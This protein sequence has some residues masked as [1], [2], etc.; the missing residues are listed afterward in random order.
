MNISLVMG[1][2]ADATSLTGSSSVTGE[3]EI[4]WAHGCC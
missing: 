4:F 1:L 2:W 3:E